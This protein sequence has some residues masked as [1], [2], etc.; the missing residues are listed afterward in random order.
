MG[1]VGP[2]SRASDKWFVAGNGAEIEKKM[3]AQNASMYAFCFCWVSSSVSHLTLP[4]VNVIKC[5]Q[6][7]DQLG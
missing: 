4:V 2:S 5:Q 1:C 6:T 3:N 7:N